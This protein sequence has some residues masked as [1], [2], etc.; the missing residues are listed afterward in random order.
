V[1]SEILTKEELED[2][3]RRALLFQRYLFRRTY[4]TYYAVWAAALS[5]FFVIPFLLGSMGEFFVLVLQVVTGIVATAVTVQ[6]FTRVIRA[7]RLW[8]AFLPRRRVPYFFHIIAWWA[9]FIL[10]IYFAFRFSTYVGYASLYLMLISVAYFLALNLKRSFQEKVPFEG[11][12]AV[13]SYGLSATASFILSVAFGSSNF[14]AVP[15][16]LTIACWIFA[17]TS[18]FRHAHEELLKEG[19]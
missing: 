4:G 3:A 12:L 7:N 2:V 9:G 14:V 11:K 13:G 19:I 15:W 18:A 16:L 5:V 6:S 17:S 10:V 8:Q 1:A